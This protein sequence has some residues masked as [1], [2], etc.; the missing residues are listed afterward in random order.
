[1]GKKDQERFLC[2]IDFEEKE[3]GREGGR[4][5]G[6]EGMSASVIVFCI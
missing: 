1:M 2:L 6:K 4:E 3:G 5:G